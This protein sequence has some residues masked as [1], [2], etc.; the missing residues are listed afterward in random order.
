MNKIKD[1][2]L[3]PFP[4]HLV[5]HAH[6]LQQLINTNRGELNEQKLHYIEMFTQH[7]GEIVA[8]ILEKHYL[9]HGTKD[10]S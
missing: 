3:I 1:H 4:T 6:T 9:T 7:M 8:G 10:I 5:E 2:V